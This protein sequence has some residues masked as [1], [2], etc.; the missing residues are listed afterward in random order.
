LVQLSPH[1]DKLTV[2]IKKKVNPLC[3]ACDFVRFTHHHMHLMMYSRKSRRPSII[4]MAPCAPLRYS[5][6]MAFPFLLSHPFCRR[7]HFLYYICKYPPAC[8]PSASN[9]LIFALSRRCIPY[10]VSIH[11]PGR[12]PLTATC[13]P[14]YPP[15]EPFTRPLTRPSKRPIAPPSSP[16]TPSLPPL[17]LLLHIIAPVSLGG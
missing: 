1:D 2:T 11:L 3:L 16:F 6:P 4:L 13:L 7:T 9:P 14:T 10:P 5:H 12:S 17:L 15:A 8:V